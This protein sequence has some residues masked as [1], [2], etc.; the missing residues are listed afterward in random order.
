MLAKG[1]VGLVLPMTVI[2]AFLIW[3]RQL[4]RLWNPSV[5]NA[6]LLFILVAGP[7][8]ALVGSETKGDFLRRLP[9]DAQRRR[10][11]AP[12]ENHG[13]P[14]FYHVFSLAFGFLPWTAFLGPTFWDALRQLRLPGTALRPFKPLLGWTLF[15]L[16]I[17]PA[18]RAGA[19]GLLPWMIPRSWPASRLPCFNSQRCSLP[20]LWYAQ[21]GPCPGTACTRGEVPG[22]LGI[23]LLRLLLLSETK[24]PNYILPVYPPMALLTARFLDR[25]RRGVVATGWPDHERSPGLLG[26]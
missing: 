26:C 13:G 21:W 11:S 8:F 23:Q 20:L 6:V 18:G 16:D 2:G 15:Y 9:P 4:R 17:L 5:L 10:F 7:W 14:F 25:W 1:P 22:L 3:T 19:G 12:M 24:L